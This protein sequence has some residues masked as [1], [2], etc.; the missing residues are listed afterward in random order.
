MQKWAK[1]EHISSYRVYDAD[2]PEYAFAIDLYNDHAV[3]Q[4]YAAP[5]TIAAHKVEQRSLDVI[6]T[7]PAILGISPDNLV[8]KQRKAQ[9]GSQ[10]YQKMAK[11]KMMIM[12][13]VKLI[14]NMTNLTL[15]WC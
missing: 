13:Q 1:R 7:T 9:K 10:Q 11:T 5:A 6:Q 4:E 8:V 15:E 2:L 3:L 12:T 14:M